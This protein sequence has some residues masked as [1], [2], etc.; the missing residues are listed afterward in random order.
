MDERAANE[1]GVH[2]EGGRLALHG[3]ARRAPIR[4]ASSP[5][6]LAA[7]HPAAG[8]GDACVALLRVAFLMR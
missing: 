3:A 7:M 8:Q 6:D 1:F 5:S 4:H 2:L